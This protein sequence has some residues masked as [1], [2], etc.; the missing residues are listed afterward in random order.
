MFM[1]VYHVKVVLSRV[2]KET[3]ELEMKERML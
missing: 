2:C 1:T 3:R